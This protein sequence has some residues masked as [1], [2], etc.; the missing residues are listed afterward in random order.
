MEL[1]DLIPENGRW[2]IYLGTFRIFGGLELIQA[3]R[4]LGYR[5]VEAQ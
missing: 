2:S 3:L 5:V 1:L 4:C